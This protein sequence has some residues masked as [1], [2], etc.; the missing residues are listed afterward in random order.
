[1]I[2]NDI[3]PAAAV[4]AA[5]ELGGEVGLEPTGDL[6]NVSILCI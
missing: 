5:E 2:W 1:V 3:I 4:A 6:A